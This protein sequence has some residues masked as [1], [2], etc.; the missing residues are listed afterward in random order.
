MKSSEFHRIIR[1]NGWIV[2]HQT[3]S[4]VIYSKEGYP[5]I[6]VPYHG[7]K[8]FLNRYGEKFVRIWGFNSPHPIQ[9]DQKQPK[10]LTNGKES[11]K[12]HH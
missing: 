6:P 11:R 4:H 2:L 10:I 3:G 5:N 9:W 8:E 1:K 12:T 7:S